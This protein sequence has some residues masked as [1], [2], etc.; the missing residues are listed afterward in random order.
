VEPGVYAGAT[1]GHEEWLVLR[2]KIIFDACKW[3]VQSEDHSVLAAFPLL[4]ESETAEFLQRAAE[5]LSQEAISAEREIIRRPKLLRRLGLP[6]KIRSA[7]RESVNA[8]YSPQ[9]LA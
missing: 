1:L 3:D 8:E 9:D 5:A 6:R 2:S 4:I 7:L